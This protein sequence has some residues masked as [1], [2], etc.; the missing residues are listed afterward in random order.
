MIDIGDTNHPF[1]SNFTTD[2][3]AHKCMLQSLIGKDCKYTKGEY[4]SF[5]D[6]LKVL[7]NKIESLPVDKN[8]NRKMLMIDLYIK[9]LDAQLCVYDEYCNFQADTMGIIESFLPQMEKDLQEM[10]ILN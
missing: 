10:N 3:E 1:I 8:R 7:Y 5:R 6:R 9:V 4:E 2:P